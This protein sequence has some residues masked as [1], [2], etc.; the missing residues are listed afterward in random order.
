MPPLLNRA[1]R[2]NYRETS[3]HADVVAF[4]RR[5][6][7]D[8]P[9][10]RVRSMGTSA[11]GRDM[12]VVVLSHRG[13]FTTGAAR[14][15]G[16]PILMIN[17]NIHAG[18]VEGKEAMLALMRELTLEGL[19][20]DLLD[21]LTLVVVPILN[22]DGND[23]ISTENRKLDLATLE[24]QIGPPGGVGTRNTGEGWNLN[25][26]Y[27]KQE[28]VESNHL[29]RLYGQ[30]WP[31]VFVDCHTTDGSIHA[32]DLTF[33][34][35][36][37]SM[38]GHPGPIEYARTELLPS[39][40]ESVQ[41][42][43]GRR[44]FFYGNYRDQD[45]P[46]S[47]WE[48]YPGLPRFGSHYRGL[49]GRMDVL[50]ETYSYIDFPARVETIRA[51]LLEI[52]KY[53][54]AHPEEIMATV[55]QAGVDTI[56]RGRNPQPDDLVGINYGAARRAADGSLEFDWPVHYLEEAEIL[57]Y[58]APS[59]RARRIPGRRLTAYRTPHYARFVPTVAVPRPYAYLIRAPEI[60]PKLLQH[61]IEVQALTEDVDL[62]IEAYVA[63]ATEKTH[64]P[65]ICTG[66]ERFETVLTVRKE[67]RRVS[68]AAGDLV[69]FAGQRLGNLLI[70]LLEPESDDGLAR[71]EYFDRHIELGQPF[72]VYRIPRPMRLATHH[73][74]PPS[75]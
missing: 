72:P 51:Y 43:I 16:I 65:D 5:L 17:C 36:H 46:A 68:F 55:D 29:S 63:L 62:E 45:D 28:A 67:R 39:V 64:S 40:A 4:L 73:Y 8:N 11:E 42:S 1:E 14:R 10:V 49:T 41:A 15:L 37:L 7:R 3:L 54:A 44:G 33:D 2:T 21:R 18:E 38:S 6:R 12:P 60:G 59:I 19:E 27:M 52:M 61:N 30:W 22:P 25:R 69:V 32:Y 23:R 9:R 57:A 66:I 71:W 70:Y 53:V 20:P 35:A 50:L 24:G 56:R 13:A 34:T 26:D 48:T 74:T 75:Q 58:D 31:H 47:G